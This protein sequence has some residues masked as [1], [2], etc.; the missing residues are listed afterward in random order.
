M[1]IVFVS[2]YINH[3]QLPFCKAML[4]QHTGEFVFIQ[5]EPM[6]EER[7]KQGW[8]ADF[9]GLPFL[10]RYDTE[11]EVCRE[12][13]AESDV[14]IF[15]GCE[16]ESFIAGR[17][18]QG[19]IV[20]RYTERI[21]REGQW[22]AISPRGLWK[23]YH[24]HTRYRNAPVYLLCAGGYVADDFSIIHAYKGK[25]FKF[26]YFTEF[27]VITPEEMD[28]YKTGDVPRIIWA[29]RFMPLKHSM[30]VLEA[31]R[32]LKEEGITFRMQ[33]V[34]DGECREEMQRFI[35]TN[36]MEKEV[37]ITGFLKPKE[38]R[39]EMK[40][41]HIFVFSSDY[42]EGW[43]A[44]M[45]EAMNA[46]CAVVA[47]HG[48]GSVPFLIEHG[49]NGLIYKS[50]DID[51]LTGHLRDL[52]RNPERCRDLGS[53]AY[54]TIAAEWNPVVAGER[55]LKLCRLLTE[56]KIQFEKSGPLS[57]AVAVKERKMYRKLTGKK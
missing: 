14:V 16:D 56:G 24:D 51:E 19:K 17:L 31:L 47:G 5:T 10:L 29:G 1:R 48:A 57:E 36:H 25:R 26:G 34:G 37:I 21:Y 9:S 4:E 7:V 28:S 53:K 23:K 44:V 33:F 2:N 38:V 18:Q 13:I 40:K 39:E 49:K 6:E 30:D 27:E 54:Q 41:S 50:C 11:P 20:L 22:K 43:G 35:E 12:W 15:G 46:G 52:C 55:L 42:K 8:A 32:R 45:N 3:H